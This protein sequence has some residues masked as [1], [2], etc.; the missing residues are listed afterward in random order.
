MTRLVPLV[1]ELIDFHHCY[2]HYRPTGDLQRVQPGS[3][4]V[5]PFYQ[6]DLF[7]EG[8]I[9]VL[10][11]STSPIATQPWSGLVIP[12]MVGHGY[13]SDRVALQ[14]TFKFQ[15]HPRHWLQFI[16]PTRVVRFP[17]LCEPL[18]RTLCELGDRDSFLWG[19]QMQAVLTLCLVHWMRDDGVDAVRQEDDPWRQRIGMCIE[20]M[21][22]SPGAEWRVAE[23]AG[24][25]QV[26]ADHFC[27]Q[28][29]RVVGLPPQRFILEF[30]MRAAA[31][32]LLNEGLAVKEVAGKLGYSSVH[33]FSR[34][35]K[36]AVGV[37]PGAYRSAPPTHR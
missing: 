15:V 23:L 19:Q 12:P 20:R 4:H 8:G 33:A 11:D 18:I 35:F 34:A 14:V 17:P 6:L 10:L 5:H 32:L 7:P 28:F 30:R 37:S 24:E 36:N 2:E 13:R 29:V 16:N 1:S 9:T 3:L 26:S 21:A 25:C 27:R 22:R 31:G